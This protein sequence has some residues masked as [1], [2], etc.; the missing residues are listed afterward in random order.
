MQ[1]QEVRSPVA[2]VSGGGTGIGRAT[3]AGLVED[4]YHVVIVGR[5]AEVLERAARKLNE[6]HPRERTAV[7]WQRADVSDPAQV[8]QMAG[9]IGDRGDVVDLIVANAGGRASSQ[10]DGLAGIAA[11]WEQSWRSNTLSAV[12]LI[13]ALRPS[14]PVPGGRIVVVG[15]R[16]ATDGSGSPEYSA[17]KAALVGWIRSLAAEVG[18]DGVTVN[19]VAPGYTEGTE[20]VAHIGAERHAR[21]ISGVAAGRAGR[22]D[23]V[24]AAVRFL[25]SPTAGYVNGQV[26]HVDGGTMPAARRQPPRP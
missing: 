20:L 5:R 14:L 11:R 18:P 26:L 8:E 23:D 1:T 3:A 9:E 15:S 17:A 7:S 25:A 22:P 16:A 19:L 24:A 21:A 4:G 10:E 13:E 12:L 2:V 6:A